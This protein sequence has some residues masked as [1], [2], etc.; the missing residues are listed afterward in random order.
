[1]VVKACLLDVEVVAY[2]GVDHGDKRIF[3]NSKC[4]LVVFVI[5]C[6][7]VSTNTSSVAILL[8]PPEAACVV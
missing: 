4:A 1:M 7:N 3:R 2:T 6:V 5:V 8:S